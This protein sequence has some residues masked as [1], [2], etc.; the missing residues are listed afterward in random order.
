VTFTDNL[1]GTATLA[2]TPALATNGTY[3]LTITASNGNLPNATQ[4]FTLTVSA[5]YR[6]AFIT[7]P[8]G[9]A[10]GVAWTQQPAVEILNASNVRVTTDS[11]STVSLAIS[12]NPAAGTLTCTGTTTSLRVT[13]GLAT[14]SGCSINVASSSPYTLGAT[15][16]PAY[17]AATSSAFYIAANRLS[18]TTQPGGGAAGVAWTQQPVVKILNASNTVVTTDS[19]STVSLAISTNPAGGTL[20]CTGGTSMRVTSGV[21]TFSGCSINLSSASAYT[22]GAT[23][24]PVWAPA[25]STGFLVTGT[26]PKLTIAV[27]S[28]PGKMPATGYTTTTPKTAKIGAYVT[29]R[30]GGGSTLAGLRVNVLIA[31]KVNGVWGNPVYYKSLWADQYGV[32]RFPYK[33]SSAAAINV[34]VQWPG[35]TTWGVSTSKALGAYW[36]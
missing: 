30:F 7:Q 20:T 12:T 8:G 31:R 33:S 23:S 9:G 21:A 11:T 2:G 6:L 24:S 18:F 13:N 32:V 27:V 1:N 10:A 25:T 22:L 5:A 4:N 29:W 3:P 14:F 16:S 36:Q 19:S 15:S 28:A 34:R 17:T 26:L 35:S